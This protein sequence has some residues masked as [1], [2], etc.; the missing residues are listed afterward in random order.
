V[1]D[2]SASL[3]TAGAERPAPARVVEMPERLQCSEE[4][5][6]PAARAINEAGLAFRQSQAEVLSL[7]SKP[8]EPSGLGLSSSVEAMNNRYER[9]SL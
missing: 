3:V 5:A 7:V 9:R 4:I 6:W 2:L 8:K 1:H